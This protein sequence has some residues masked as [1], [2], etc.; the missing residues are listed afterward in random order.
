MALVFQRGQALA[1]GAL[2]FPALELAATLCGDV[3]LLRRPQLLP[4]G[5]S[6]FS[7]RCRDERVPELL[8][9][10]AVRPTLAVTL[11][12]AA[13]QFTF[14]LGYVSFG[15]N[16]LPHRPAPINQSVSNV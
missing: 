14:E 11:C 12:I 2:L 9:I 13:P 7:G 10:L 3:E 4:Y 8:H 16:L 1:Q 6:C 15:Y 5:I